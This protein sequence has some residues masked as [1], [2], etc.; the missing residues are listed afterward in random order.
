MRIAIGLVGA[1][2]V[3]MPTMRSSLGGMQQVP[4]GRIDDWHQATSLGNHHG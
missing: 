3:L 2:F 4:R 1:E